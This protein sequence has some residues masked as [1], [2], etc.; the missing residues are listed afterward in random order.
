M[1]RLK[2]LLTLLPLLLIA[3]IFLGSSPQEKRQCRKNY[4]NFL[5]QSPLPEGYNDLFAGSG[6]CLLCHNSM[7]NAQGDSIGILNDWRSTMMANS[8]KDPFWR[9]K[10]SHETQVNPAHAEALEDV[11]TRCH[12]PAG[13]FNAHF[14]GSPFYSIEE[15]AADPLAL[16]GGNCTVCHQIMQEI[17]GNHSGVIEF[18]TDKII[19]G[20][21]PDPF[22]VPMFNNTGY[23]PQ[24][25]DHIK[26]SRLCGACHTLLTNSVDLNGNLTGD[27]F[28]EQAIYQEWLNSSYPAQGYGCQSC[29]IPEIP[30]IIKIS[31]MPPWLEG[32]SPFGLHH[33]VGGNVFMQRI[34]R[35]NLVEL[36]ITAEIK[37]IDSTM[38]RTLRLLRESTLGL[39]LSEASRTPDTLFL[40][41]VLENITGHKLPTGFPSRRVFVEIIAVNELFDTIFHSGQTDS[42][43]ELIQEDSPYELHHK[44]IDAEDKV[45][46]Y[47]M[48][49]GDVDGNLTT[50]LERGFSHLKDN[51]IPPEGFTSAHSAYDTVEIAGLSLDDNDFNKDGNIEG[52]GADRIL[53]HIPLEG[54][55]GRVDI[56]VKAHYQTVNGKWLNDLFNYSSVEIDAWESFYSNS[57]RRPVLINEA[58]LSSLA[59][60]IESPE[61]KDFSIFPN[62]SNE[63]FHILHPENTVEICEVFEIGG[64]LIYSAVIEGQSSFLDLSSYKSG[65]YLVKLTC[66]D[67]SEIVRKVI[68]R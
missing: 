38:D 10:V 6:E 31:L 53:I 66:S 45:Q 43:F 61:N 41:A 46:I 18:G 9:A 35:E 62:P 65:I 64:K 20:Q 39:S 37:H 68:L 57:D 67:N 55:T 13:H 30:D 5:V 47:E 26:D 42:I 1:I 7:T 16:D 56:T 54:Y 25:S 2:Y 28:V 12:A 50:V 63:V 59:I 32:R 51:R 14:I 58:S 24:Y 3:A 34:F 23:T 29:H 33:L 22:T 60:S 48:V 21:Y 17:L 15:M 52:T 11:C 44:V 27:E 4:F 19:W 36:G 8:S 49:M 40:E